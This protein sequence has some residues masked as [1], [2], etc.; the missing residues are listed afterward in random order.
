MLK[1]ELEQKIFSRKWI[2]LFPLA[3]SGVMFLFKFEVMKL[4]NSSNLYQVLG[5]CCSSSEGN[6]YKPGTR[7][8]VD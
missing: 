1:V 3:A 7:H 2:K 8:S 6:Q 5:I 4:C